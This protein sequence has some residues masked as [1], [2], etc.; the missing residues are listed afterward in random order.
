MRRQKLEYQKQAEQNRGFLNKI[1]KLEPREKSKDHGS[2]QPAT[3]Q[4][5]EDGYLVNPNGSNMF[6]NTSNVHSNHPNNL[7]NN[8]SLNNNQGP[9]NQHNMEILSRLSSNIDQRSYG[10]HDKYSKISG[11][12]MDDNEDINGV[13]LSNANNFEDTQRLFYSKCLSMK[14]K[15][16]STKALT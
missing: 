13:D 6:A 3:G 14:M 8:T 1:I 12:I 9:N 10:D 11:S 5:M 15:L 16:H 7:S 2:N 4:S